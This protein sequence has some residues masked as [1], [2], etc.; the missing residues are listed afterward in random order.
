MTAQLH[1][2]DRRS[3]DGIEVALLWRKCDNS[4]V[5][6]VADAKTGCSFQLEV[7]DG[8]RALEVFHHPYAYAALHCID[9]DAPTLDE[10]PRAA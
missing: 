8:E 5:V 4:V 2:L 7:R 9:T 6:E 3:C 10:L 1:E